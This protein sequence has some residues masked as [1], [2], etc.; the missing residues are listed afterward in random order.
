MAE[1]PASGSAQA[2]PDGRLWWKTDVDWFGFRGQNSCM[3]LST[4]LPA[5]IVLLVCIAACDREKPITQEVRTNGVT[6]RLKDGDAEV[7][8]AGEPRY[9]RIRLTPKADLIL[10]ERFD[11]IVPPDFMSVLPVSRNQGTRQRLGGFEV[12]CM[13]DPPSYYACGTRSMY[14]GMPFVLLFLTPPQSERDVAEQIDLA[15]TFLSRRVQPKT[16]TRT[17]AFPTSK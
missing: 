15:N 4:H 8:S 17:T 2:Q 9:A 7:Y 14:D 11:W 6:I 5:S 10:D 3:R 12:A 1:R 16:V 13:P